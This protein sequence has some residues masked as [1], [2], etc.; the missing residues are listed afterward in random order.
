MIYKVQEITN[1]KIAKI[2]LLMINTICKVQ[3]NILIH[4]INTLKK[5]KIN[6]NIN[7]V[8]QR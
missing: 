1:K 7:I 2:L 5:Y 6:L 8:F 3:E 4:K